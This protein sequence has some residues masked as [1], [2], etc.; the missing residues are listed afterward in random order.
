MRYITSKEAGQIVGDPNVNGVPNNSFVTKSDLI[1]HNKFKN[2]LLQSYSNTD[3]VLAKDVQ[4]GAVRLSVTMASDVFLRGIVQINGDG[5][6][7]NQSKEIQSGGSVTVYCHL[8]DSKDVFDGWYNDRNIKVSS[9]P[10]YTFSITEPTSLT[11]KSLF[12]DIDKS[13]IHFSADGG[14]ETI[15]IS[16]NVPWNVR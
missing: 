9:N 4:R 2:S 3:F 11:A 15:N 7:S 14:S 13:S 5:N 8:K 1:T 16:S 6:S 10:S 12:I